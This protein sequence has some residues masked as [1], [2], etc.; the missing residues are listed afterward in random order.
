MNTTLSSIVLAGLTLAWCTQPIAAQM[1]KRWS[2][3]YD[4]TRFALANPAVHSTA[5]DLRLKDLHG[6]SRSL[7]AERGR[8]I[9]LIAGSYT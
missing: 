5:P 8:T 6:R 1:E 4:T 2:D 3:Q 9:V 7:H